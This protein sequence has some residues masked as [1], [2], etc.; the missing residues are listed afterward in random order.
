MSETTGESTTRETEGT[1]TQ[2]QGFVGRLLSSLVRVREV[3][4]LIVLVGLA[5][6]FQA[7]NSAFLSQQNILSL[8]QY[9]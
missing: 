5:L 9:A 1:G 2:E 3:S 7:A 6:Y 8:A 4:I